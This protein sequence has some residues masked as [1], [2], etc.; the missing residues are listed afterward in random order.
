ML[1]AKRRTLSAPMVCS[2]VSSD[3]PRQMPLAE[4]HWLAKL[5]D[6]TLVFH[7]AELVER[8]PVFGT[9]PIPVQRPVHAL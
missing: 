1:G 6:F 3:C 2:S 5:D 8:A 4:E 7:R 9:G